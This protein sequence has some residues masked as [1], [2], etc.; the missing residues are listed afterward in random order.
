MGIVLEKT[1][2]VDYSE[3][4]QYLFTHSLINSKGEARQPDSLHFANIVWEHKDSTAYGRTNFRKIDHSNFI[5]DFHLD[6]LSCARGIGEYLGGY[7]RTDYDK[8][9]QPRHAEGPIDVGCY[10]YV[11]HEE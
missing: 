4:A 6:S 1:D 3:Y 8:D 11:A 9:G 10:Q 2:S 5:Y 7:P